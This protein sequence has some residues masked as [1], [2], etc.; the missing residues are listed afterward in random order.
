MSHGWNKEYRSL[1]ANGGQRTCWQLRFPQTCRIVRVICQ[2]VG[3]QLENGSAA[4][5]TDFKLKLFNSQRPCTGD[6]ASSG[7]VNDPEGYYEATPS[8]YQV[9]E[10][11]NGVAGTAT[12]YLEAGYVY[13]NQDGNG[14]S[15]REYFIYVQIDIEALG[16]YV[17]DLAIGVEMD[18]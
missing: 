15:T 2:Q 10:T 16:E 5:L 8:V 17:F 1:H 18:P 9:I 13:Q 14:P 3:G 12:L 4:P 11:L 6:S 7:G